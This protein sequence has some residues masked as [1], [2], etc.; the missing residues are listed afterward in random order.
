MKGSLRNNVVK[1]HDLIF[2][3]LLREKIVLR[4][5]ELFKRVGL[6]HDGNIT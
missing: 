5:E 6:E 1:K 2:Q 3:K 4:F